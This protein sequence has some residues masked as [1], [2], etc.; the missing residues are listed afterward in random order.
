[1]TDVG[2]DVDRCGAIQNTLSAHI[3]ET[4]LRLFQINGSHSRES[5]QLLW[6]R[7]LLQGAAGS[8]VRISRMHIKVDISNDFI[9]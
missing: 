3:S 9:V 5:T 1:M 2:R 4:A 8:S 6:Q 7:I